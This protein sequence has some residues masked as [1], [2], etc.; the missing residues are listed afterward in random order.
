[1]Y[2]A[3]KPLT[4]LS[5]FIDPNCDF[6]AAPER[7]QSVS[8][9]ANTAVAG[10]SRGNLLPCLFTRWSLSAEGCGR[11]LS[12]PGSGQGRSRRGGCSSSSAE[13]R[14][15]SPPPSVPPQGPAGASTEHMAGS[16]R[17][18]GHGND[19]WCYGVSGVMVM[20]PERSDYTNKTTGK[21]VI[22]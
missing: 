13:G 3:A 7:A 20:M 22:R 2:I 15:T 1:M 9:Q 18:P 4:C 12:Q 14:T 16:G 17:E 6:L 11:R 21:I 10:S 5:A 19:S 8:G